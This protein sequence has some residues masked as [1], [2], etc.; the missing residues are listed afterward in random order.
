MVDEGGEVWW[1][2]EVG[3]EVDGGKGDMEDGKRRAENE[4][5]RQTTL[6]GW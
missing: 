2:K 5:F 1:M 6:T 3:G 4:G